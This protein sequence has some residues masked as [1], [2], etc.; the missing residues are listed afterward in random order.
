MAG[1][2]VVG[3]HGVVIGAPPQ[4]VFDYLADMARHVEWN[5]EVE[6]HVTA[7]PEGTPRLG[8]VYSR[9]LTGEM[10]GYL[11]LGATWGGDNKVTVVKITTIA[12][13]EPYFGLVFETRNSYNGLLHSVEKVSFDLRQEI[14][15]TMVTM[16][17]EVEAMVPSA[18][19]GPVYAIRAFRA[20]FDR[21]FGG[22]LSGLFPA[23]T[24]GPHLSR[25]K[26]MVERGEI[27]G[28]I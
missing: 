26:E 25:V 11:M 5:G 14:E 13:C 7:R 3:R 22:L 21:L 9:E 19:I 20:A 17:S 4:Q 27:A 18:F 1:P 6:F 2:F 28:R 15:G 12:V 23:M 16:V 24:A 10:G 8:S